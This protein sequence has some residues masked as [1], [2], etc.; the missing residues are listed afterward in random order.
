MSERI[1]ITD[2]VYYPPLGE[3]FQ[4]HLYPS[5]DGGMVTFQRTVTDQKRTEEELH[6]T[7]TELA[8]VG[9]V[10]T[11]G[12]LTAS[13]AHEVN[14][15]LAAVVTNTHACRRWL[16]RTPPDLAEAMDALVRIDRD[17]QR[18]GNVIA[19]LRRLAM[20]RETMSQ[21][22][23]NDVIDEV[24]TLVQGEARSRNVDL[25]VGRIDPPSVTADRVQ[26]QQVLLNLIVNGMDAMGS[27]ED[28]KRELVVTVS[29]G[30]RE[31][32]A[33]VRDSGV[34]IHPRDRDRVFDAFYTTK[35]DGMGMGLAIS[36]TIVESHGGR[37]WA[38]PN[39]GP[40]ET[41]SFSLPLA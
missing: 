10:L 30:S 39:E 13:I 29:T 15:P 18:A 32:V 36:R 25:Q 16:S 8:R 9:R 26:L 11:M 33:S 3:W 24:I 7:R 31:L 27:V 34:G 6:Q 5:E 19:G 37:L 4:N 20:R 40:G 28:R 2:E 12:E 22:R 14:Q 23:M 17:A 35:P 38:T 21:V 1:S 41:F